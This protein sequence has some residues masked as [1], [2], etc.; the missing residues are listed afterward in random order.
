MTTKFNALIL[1]DEMDARKMIVE[2]CRLYAPFIKTCF[3]ADGIEAAKNIITEHEIAL[4]FLDIQLKN[5]NGFQLL[6][7]MG[8]ITPAVIFTTAHQQFAA[9]AFRTAALDYLLKPVQPQSFK[10][11]ISRFIDA[12]SFSLNEQRLAV[13]LENLT[14][15]LNEVNRIAIPIKEGYVFEPANQIMYVQ[16]DSNYS[17]I[18]TIKGK[19][20]LV[21]R[22]LRYFEDL[23]PKCFH[24]IHKSS[25]VNL[26][27]VMAY[28]KETDCV[29]LNNN[30]QL[31]V[32]I[33]AKAELI[34]RFSKR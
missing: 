16:G 26:N 10:E 27:Y 17:K 28:N 19:E 12:K 3:E 23:L 4:I 6:E 34:A 8:T 2:Y 9:K 33:R 13:L 20:Y 7:Q 32:S 30:H 5:E 22:T 24:R 31:A 29:V 15:P 14:Q 21:S 25:L 11:A 18:Y 1:D